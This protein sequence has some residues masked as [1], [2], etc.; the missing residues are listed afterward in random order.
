[1][2]ADPDA[3][4]ERIH[5]WLEKVYTIKFEKGPKYS[6][7]N[8]LTD[9]ETRVKFIVRKDSSLMQISC[10]PRL[11]QHNHLF[12]L[13]DDEKRSGITNSIIAKVKEKRVRCEFTSHKTL[14]IS[15]VVDYNLL[16]SV[17]DRDYI[18]NKVKL[19]L[20]CRQIAF[21]IIDE[22]LT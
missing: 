6:V 13:L 21:K 8:A 10:V 7:L 18:L 16:A 22:L 2:H 5:V 1:M 3:L 19:M 4:D 11:E 12:T 9:K 17:I 15:E 20:E 14:V